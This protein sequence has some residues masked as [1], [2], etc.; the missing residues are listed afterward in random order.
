ML[1]LTTADVRMNAQA[2][3]KQQALQ[4]LAQI[5]QDDG[6]AT[7]DYLHGLMDRESQA[8]TYLG[9]G[10]AIPHGTP[11]SR[12]AIIQTGVR[13]VNF[14][15]GV[16]WNDAGDKVYL[17]VVIAAKSDEHLQ[18]LQK[19]THALQDDVADSI[20]KA[21]NADEIMAALGG[22]TSLLIQ[23]SLID[24]QVGGEQYDEVFLQSLSRLK[25][26]HA[27]SSRA[28]TAPK[29]TVL[30][31][32][33]SCVILENQPQILTSAFA[34]SVNP[35]SKQALAVI[36]ADKKINTDKLSWLYDV[37]M[38]DA[39]AQAVQSGEKEAILSQLG[40]QSQSDWQSLSVILPNEHGLHARPATALSELA[41]SFD[42][43]IRVQVDGG[44]FVSAKSL[45]R[46]LSL[47]AVKG[48]TLTFIAQP[49][50]DAQN[51]LPK[52]VEAVQAGLGESVSATSAIPVAK[53]QTDQSDNNQVVLV[54]GEKIRAVAAST[55]LAVGE[56]YVSKAV[57]YNYSVTAQDPAEQMTQ[58][59]TAINAVKDDLRQLVASAKNADI[60]QIFT[61]HIALLED[62]EVM[63]GAKDGIDDGLSAPAAWHT[64]IEE[65]AVAQASL[66]NHLLAE[67]A[68][69]LRDVGHKVLLKLIGKTEQAAPQNPY[70]LI[71]EDL[72]P[73]DVA[74]LDPTK[75]AGIIT[76]V[77]GSSSH[78]AIVARAL[79]IPALVGAGQQVLALENGTQILLDGGEGWFVVNPEQSLI[80]EC[81]QAQSLRR[82]Q[83]RQAMQ[84]AHEPAITLDGHRVE[85]AVN[86]GNV[87][88][89][90]T[91][92]AN[93]AEGVGLL[94][95][96][97]VF[98][99][100]HQVPDIDQQIADYEQV[101]DALDGRPLVV[102]VLDIGGDKALPYLPMAAEENP[103]LGLR[104]IRLLLSRPELL[105]SQLTALIK[106]S[107]GRDLR[108]MF[109]MIG[110]LEEW[111]AARAILDEVLAEHPHD[112]LQV[113]I[114]LEV[115]S[116][117][118]MAPIFA[119]EVDFFSVG[120]NDLTQYVL[121]IDRGHPL[122]SKDAD[123]LHPS[124]LTLIAQTVEAAHA[125]GK[126]VGVCGELASDP[127]AVPILVGL[128]V[129][130]LSMSSASIALT[131]AKIRALTLADAQSLA[132]QALQCD[133]A[134]AVRE[135]SL[136][137]A[138]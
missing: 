71:K 125:H 19:L 11:E 79:G 3:D 18:I 39:F 84:H 74:N 83:K 63:F 33:V 126:W 87:A 134:M 38:S 29:P 30:S 137:V 22:T 112:N 110:R 49:D 20:A 69:D 59:Q 94:R 27:I 9:Q 104:G 91:A 12:E 6:L 122:L 65:L 5:L 26:H 15:D 78:S 117:A 118:V 67:R 81:Q 95:T 55:G 106:A 123:G 28:I 66:G 44:A 100:H 16:V 52:L 13:L 82:E 48:Q 64:F 97:L 25:A 120:T 136:T 114:M 96:E 135:L 43:D 119:K 75:V 1:T 101:F 2:S 72:L 50:T 105:R 103:F 42:G 37:L 128:G 17:A 85:V 129:D 77:G 86:L 124:I 121:A 34:L 32:A 54:D 68:A 45:T 132:K 133:S 138:R 131:K 31:Q 4:V 46:L 36:T 98:M 58:L 53:K 10:I 21:T 113:G 47:G 80:E 61:A 60:A 109:P 107:K 51:A 24:T 73:S 102:R 92:V 99:S 76:A 115:P 108:I 130:E 88:D 56:S 8:A 116:A 41:K 35:N 23:E 7:A 62:E 127:A 93:G 70:V 57:K 89:T 111:R 40:I 14:A 90:A